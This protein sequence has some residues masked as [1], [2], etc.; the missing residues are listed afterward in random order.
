MKKAISLIAVVA[1]LCASW[2]WADEV[3]TRNSVTLRPGIT[4][5]NNSGRAG[6]CTMSEYYGGSIGGLLSDVGEYYAN[7]WDPNLDYGTGCTAPFLPFHITNV[8]VDMAANSDGTGGD[9]GQT[10]TMTA[11]IWCPKDVPTGNVIEACKG[12]GTILASVTV[13]YT[14]TDAD[15]AGGG[16]IFAM[17]FPFDVCVGG[18][19]FAGYYI[20][21]WTGVAGLIPISLWQPLALPAATDCVP[22]GNF[23]LGRGACWYAANWDFGIGSTNSV[24]PWFV[25]VS[26]DAGAACTPV[27]CA[28]CP[29]TLVGENSADPMHVNGTPWT[30][31]FNLCDYCSDYDV[32]LD[33]ELISTFGYSFTGKGGDVVLQIDPIPGTPANLTISIVP[34]CNPSTYNFR[35]RWWLKDMYGTYAGSGI[36]PFGNPTYG[37]SVSITSAVVGLFDAANGPI[38]L[39]I[40]TRGCCCPIRVT[41]T[42]DQI[43]PVEISS[44]DATAGNG[45]VSLNWATASE[46]NI[47]RYD[48][49]RND[50]EI[51]GSV[52]SLGNSAAGHHYTFVDRGLENG[53]TYYYQLRAYDLTGAMVNQTGV[54][55]ATP[56]VG[57]VANEYALAQNFPNPFNPSTQISYSVKEAGLVTLKVYSLDGREVGTLVNNSQ[58][59]GVYT[60][61]FDGSNLASGVYVYT[62]N[63]NGFSASHKMVL[64]K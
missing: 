48:V 34:L 60:V 63:V 3:A 58:D 53:R 25:F 15:T 42:G 32:S 43:L 54:A 40:D 36:S 13:S 37:A 23:D 33:N 1:L 27:A 18:P 19:F 6:S 45:E 50:G 51:I 20:E 46:N 12:P 7:Y 61:D 47:D 44:F 14:L 11:F 10:L 62:L 22:W 56:H 38:Q 55:T 30:H 28:P 64:M 8:E 17:N 41:V 57:L 5:P 2:A 35:I 59:T 9:L 4:L 16:Q 39:F 24:G 52:G 21:S 49:V 31:E 26:G 29:R